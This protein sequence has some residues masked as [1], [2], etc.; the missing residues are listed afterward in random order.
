VSLGIVS[1]RPAEL[2]A[3][4]LSQFGTIIA[5]RMSNERDQAFVR[6]VLPDGSEWLISSLPALA[7]GEAVVIGEGVAVPMR[8]RFS[9]LQTAHQPASQTPA[10]S[11][12]WDDDVPGGETLD[13][14]VTRWRSLR[15]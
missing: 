15:R 12:A 8:I 13:E 1:Q 11:R 14:V 10:F 7:T 4:S 5:L 2:S 6:N 3:T 9:E